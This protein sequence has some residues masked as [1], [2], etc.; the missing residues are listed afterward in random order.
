M[1][2]T[3]AELHLHTSESSHC[4][5]VSAHES[6]PL[7]KE[8]GYDLV[9]I[10]DHFNRRYFPSGDISPAEWKSAVEKW[11]AGW[12]AAREE[13]EKC[14]ITVLHGAEFE[15]DSTDCEYLVYGVTDEMF[16]DIPKLYK[17]TLP[18]FSHFAEENGIFVALAHPYRR[19]ER[20]DPRYYSGAEVF[21]GHPGHD[22]HNEMAAAFAKKHGLIPLCGQDFHFN[23]AM[24]GI[25]TRFYGEIKDLKALV[26]KLFAKD[27]D[28]LLPCGKT[29][30]AKDF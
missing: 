22:A 10:T 5:E 23:A 6:I 11:F 9:C 29:V 12:Y 8:N 21:N 27:Y 4:G 18:E 7:F 15:L 13:G 16:L 3:Y 24:T 2:Y 25:K 14:G 1:I 19:N 20:P 28:M 30:R 26:A 17:M